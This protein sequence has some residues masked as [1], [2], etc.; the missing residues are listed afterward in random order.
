[1]FNCCDG[2]EKIIYTISDYCFITLTDFLQ[3]VC[4]IVENKDDVGAF[5]DFKD[6]G[7]EVVGSPSA[8]SET[9]QEP[10]S[11]QEVTASEP[12]SNEDL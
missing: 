11:K 1:M 12:V 2:N 4:I 8:A 9:V 5:K 10:V 6:E 7:G 3:L